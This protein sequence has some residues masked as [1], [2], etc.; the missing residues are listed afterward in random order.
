MAAST[1]RSTSV[2]S[3]DMDAADDMGMASRHAS[4]FRAGRVV[5]FVEPGESRKCYG[6]RIHEHHPDYSASPKFTIL[7]DVQ[8]R[9]ES[10]PPR[11][12]MMQ[13]VVKDNWIGFRG[14][15]SDGRY[16]Q[17][18]RR[19]R[20]NLRFFNL[21]FGVWEQ[22]HVTD[23]SNLSSSS[24]RVALRNRMLNN[25]T[26][27][28]VVMALDAILPTTSVPTSPNRGR[29]VPRPKPSPTNG[30]VLRTA[31]ID[32]ESRLV[33]LSMSLVK[34][35]THRATHRKAAAVLRHWRS[36]VRSRGNR[37][38]TRAACF[39]SWRKRTVASR[40]RARLANSLLRSK[41]RNRS[42]SIIRLWR[43]WAHDARRV[44]DSIELMKHRN[45]NVLLERCL[46]V[47]SGSAALQKEKRGHCDSI[48]RKRLLRRCHRCWRRSVGEQQS[49]RLQLTKSERLFRRKTLS[50]VVTGWMSVARAMSRGRVFTER[51][52]SAFAKQRCQRILMAWFILTFHDDDAYRSRLMMSKR[53]FLRHW[54]QSRANSKSQVLQVAEYLIRRRFLMMSRTILAWYALW[55]RKSHTDAIVAAGTMHILRGC[56]KRTVRAWKYA[57]V[58]SVRWKAKKARAVTRARHNVL[59]KTVSQW[60]KFCERAQKALRAQ[61]YF[62]KALTMSA[63]SKWARKRLRT[64]HS[65]M[66]AMH[67]LQAIEKGIRLQA[68]T[69]WRRYIQHTAKVV[70][71]SEGY[72]RHKTR[73]QRHKSLW[74]AWKAWT[75]QTKTASS[76]TQN[77]HNFAK[78]RRHH[79]VSMAFDTWRSTAAQDKVSRQLV[80]RMLSR[81]GSRRQ[82]TCF[83]AWHALVVTLRDRRDTA[84][85]AV[86]RMQKSFLS[87]AFYGWVSA[88]LNDMHLRF[89]LESTFLRWDQRRLSMA[90]NM[91]MYVVV[92]RAEMKVTLD[93]FLK[94][95]EWMKLRSSIRKWMV[96][97]FVERGALLHLFA[98]I[99]RYQYD[100]RLMVRCFDSWF[101]LVKRHVH[102]RSLVESMFFKRQMILLR[103][104]LRCWNLSVVRSRQGIEAF[105]ERRHNLCCAQVL[106]AW[107]HVHIA[108]RD[109]KAR[110]RAFLIRWTSR[111][112]LSAF[113]AWCAYC[114]SLRAKR[115]VIDLITRRH[116]ERALCR[117]F[118]TWRAA[119]AMKSLED[120]RNSDRVG[121]VNVFRRRTVFRRLQRCFAAWKRALS[122]SRHVARLAK[123]RVRNRNMVT[124]RYMWR[125][126][127]D[128]VKT[129]RLGTRHSQAMRARRNK[130]IMTLHFNL[131]LSVVM[132]YKSRRSAI[133][134]L[135]LR[136]QRVN[137][138]P[139]FAAWKLGRTLAIME[140]TSARE[141]VAREKSRMLAA[142]FG[143]WRHEARRCRRLERLRDTLSLR[144]RRRCL[145][146]SFGRWIY[147]CSEELNK[148]SSITRAIAKDQNR[149]IR[150]TM[151]WWKDF[152]SSRKVADALTRKIEAVDLAL[153]RAHF[154]VWRSLLE[155]RKS[156]TM[157]ADMRRLRNLMQRWM[158]YAD[159]HRVQR[160]AWCAWKA[161]LKSNVSE[162]S[163][164]RMPT[165]TTAGVLVRAEGSLNDA[166]SKVLEEC[167][168]LEGMVQKLDERRRDEMDRMAQDSAMIN[169]TLNELGFQSALI[170]MDLASASKTPP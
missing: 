59:H 36:I 20:G 98:R 35:F 85:N 46:N 106:E 1:S 17:T 117:G 44:S 75:L 101:E 132:E 71:V 158:Y 21:N 157:K 165:T 135:I 38:S 115:I 78:R 3:A 161:S 156:I 99:Y 64:K 112:L 16:L 130:R 55:V 118:T 148:K 87:S 58:E 105:V 104:S 114:R 140:K 26:I 146:K 48:S 2:S 164:S 92:S 100:R 144:R 169:F 28:V 30:N 116:V 52:L 13:I 41:R 19:P 67:R 111:R 149:I 88:H 134:A 57:A 66:I 86:L 142:C 51:V 141:A 83:R 47:W 56:A 125:E 23:M 69:R 11:R 39:G 93:P 160:R 121:V 123:S 103:S 33:E 120:M 22:W 9:E 128:A 143:C 137:L 95:M 94:R 53:K 82:Y 42:R 65:R 24:C 152:I 150:K 7:H 18:T 50:K 29:N 63:F 12:C 159:I 110:L 166:Y 119:L 107:V 145:L 109:L 131:W 43:W 163:S 14:L 15:T 167:Q 126:W 70:A 129:R 90:F 108:E 113:A 127:R 40:M 76:Q 74:T 80:T 45:D 96:V 31:D 151:R 79:H 49:H 81:Q 168:A 6:V 124:I 25:F 153:K 138:A 68:F 89:T 4:F 139:A 170:N 10:T 147:W 5:Y 37:E 133:D 34:K 32:G 8:H 54:S 162:P 122:G 102:A 84:N 27:S 77:A 72:H 155:Y 60:Q 91:W 136:S 154:A 61:T 73:S 62:N 97:T